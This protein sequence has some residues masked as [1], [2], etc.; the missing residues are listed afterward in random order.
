MNK[1]ELKKSPQ[2]KKGEMKSKDFYP[3]EENRYK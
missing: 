2:V 1:E 3:M